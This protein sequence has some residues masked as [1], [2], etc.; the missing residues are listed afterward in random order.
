[1]SCADVR[2]HGDGWRLDPTSCGGGADRACRSL[3][4]V[5]EAGE[6]GPVELACEEGDGPCGLTCDGSQA[7]DS[8]WLACPDGRECTLPAIIS[9]AVFCGQTYSG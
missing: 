7:C 9:P 4:A 1:M 8:A 2:L 5:D 3:R 6:E